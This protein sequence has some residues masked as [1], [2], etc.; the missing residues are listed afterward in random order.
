MHW[1]TVLVYPAPKGVP[2]AK[3]ITNKWTPTQW[4]EC[5]FIHMGADI[6]TAE[7]LWAHAEPGIRCTCTALNSAWHTSPI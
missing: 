1:A 2:Q 5:R 4:F 3:G 6:H 7:M